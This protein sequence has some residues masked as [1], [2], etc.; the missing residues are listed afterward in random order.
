VLSTLTA[1]V[2]CLGLVAVDYLARTWRVQ[3]LARGLHTRI[4]FLDVFTL[5]AAGDATA[6]LTPLKMGGEPIRFGGLINGGLNVSDTIALISVESVMEWSFIITIGVLIGLRW[7][8]EWWRTE[9]QVLVPHLRHAGPVVALIVGIGIL[10]W[11]ALRKFMPQ[12][13]VYVGGT[14]RDSIRLAR[15][16]KAWAVIACIPLTVVHILARVSILPVI[17]AT[18]G[19]PP[20]LGT[21]IVGSFALLYGQNFLPTPSGAGAVE[22]G[23]LNGAVGYVGPDVGA[24]LVMWR[25][26]TTV[27]GIVIGFPFGVAMYAPALHRIGRRIFTSFRDHD[28]RS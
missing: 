15:R 27:V 2:L 3:L 22:L 21:V 5:N 28:A 9:E 26:Y 18:L 13:S 16:M 12:I 24:L 25:L 20:A 23:F 19:T 8:G 4:R 11:L 7:G 1:H 17:C 6:A 10:I 14:L